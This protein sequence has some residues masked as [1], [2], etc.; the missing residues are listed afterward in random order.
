M[1]NTIKK[2][3][4]KEISDAVTSTYQNSV[5]DIVNDHCLRI[6]VMEGAYKW[7]YHEHSDELFISLEGALK[8]EIKDQEALILNPGEFAMIP[9][10]TIHKTTAIGRSVNLCFE[11][12]AEDT[13]FVE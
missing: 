11:K 1:E 4:F 9:A 5:I 12:N 7:H 6:S 13:I 3:S 8:I 2:A 10:K